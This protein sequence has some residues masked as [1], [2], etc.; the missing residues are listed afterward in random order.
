MRKS[1]LTT[2]FVIKKIIVNEKNYQGLVVGNLVKY[3]AGQRVS[4]S[5]EKILIKFGYES[6][7]MMVR[8]FK[9]VIENDE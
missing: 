8:E 5:E 4:E 3:V 1:N 9:R 7:I 2:D 6:G